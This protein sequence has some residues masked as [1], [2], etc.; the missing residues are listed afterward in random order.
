MI[1]AGA[2]SPQ[3]VTAD[4]A[5]PGAGRRAAGTAIELLGG[6][7]VL[8]NDAGGGAAG[9][10]WR[11]A[12]GPEAREAFEV[13]YWS[14]L[15]LLAAVVP[16]MLRR[17]SGTVVNVTSLGQVMTWP[18]M[19]PYTTTK[20]ALAMATET[21]RLELATTDIRVIEVIP[22]PV[23][24][25]VQAE[26]SLLPGFRAAMRFAPMGD[27]AVLATRIVK[28]IE[29]GGD[30]LVYPGSLR[31]AYVLPGATRR[32]VA[33]LARRHARGVDDARVLRS[34]SVGDPAA[35]AAREAWATARTEVTG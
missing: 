20:A 11:A 2:P 22:G 25:A 14:P 28:A 15:A 35:R 27:P 31:G 10:M 5:R 16:G 9:T 18:M 33:R 1:Q 21:L 26:S 3:V 29:G 7:D 4:L 32:Y 12:D 23:A 24:T 8:V 17:R 30:R 13:N 6:V 19:G 34:G